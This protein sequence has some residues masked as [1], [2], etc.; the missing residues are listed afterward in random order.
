MLKHN[1]LLFLRNVKKNKTTFLI[2]T[3][4]LGIGIASFLLL[5]L[6]VFNDLTYNHFHD[7]LGNIYRV[8]EGEGVQTK[9]LLL[10]KMLEDIP[11]IEKGTRIFDWDGSRLS[12]GDVAFFENIN[13]VDT[14]FFEIFTFPFVEGPVNKDVQEKYGVVISTEFAKKYFGDTPALGKQLQVKYD[15]MF[16]TVNG[17]VAVPENSSI[18]FDIMASYETGEEVMSWMKEVHNWQNTFSQTYVQ[19]RKG[20]HP[21]DIQD[22]M[23]KIVSENFF[24]VGESKAKLG[25]LP[26]EKYHAVEESN[27]TLIIILAIIALGIIGIA[28]INFINLT[29][30]HS[31]SRIKEM[32]IKKV[33]GATRRTLIWQIMTEAFTTSFIALILGVVSMLVL[34][35]TFNGLF[36][37]NLRF[38][39][40]QNTFFLVILI[41]IWGTIGLLSGFIASMFWA[42]GR[43]IESLKGNL[44]SGKKTSTSRHSLI[45]VQFVIAIV[46][47]SGTILIRKQIDTMLDKDPKFDNENVIITELESWQFENLETASQNFKRIVEELEAS[48]YVESVSFSNNVP[49][50]YQENYNI[51]YP[52]DKKTVDVLHIRKA[53]VGADYFKTLG[54]NLLNGIGFEGDDVS[55]KN[56]VVLNQKAMKDLGFI[57]VSGQMLYEGSETGE[58]YKVIGTID[59]FSYQ[60]VQRE[61]QPLAHFFSERENLADWNYMSVKSKEGSALQVMNL[62]KN[63]WDMAFSGL[64]PNSF[65]ADDKLNEQYKEYVKV[66]TL[67]AWFS[68]LA[69]LLSCMGLFA[70]AS[71]MMARRKKE[72]GIRK[73]NGAT[74]A[75]VLVLLNKDFVKWVALAFV[76][77]VPISS[78]AMGKWLEGFAYKTNISWWIFA[79]AGIV[80]LAIALLT[81]SWQSFRAA[82]NNPV[83][84]LRNE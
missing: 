16:L 12:Q 67:I 66:N 49:G 31:M 72:I 44:F 32:G 33:H 4:G 7:N 69:V 83:D 61:I 59:D 51:F 54:I 78:Y 29:I 20:V 1:I 42:K 63:K 19:L 55:Y 27:Q 10:P 75:Q 56:T 3:I 74:I 18:K 8:R 35:P 64:E 34:L 79:L 9:G 25:L 65:F 38:Q 28:I 40:F 13:Y 41:L 81:V 11:E 23:Q 52:A 84:A 37:T 77:A 39:P 21:A 60:G 43:L 46:L 62:L 22:K 68:V 26:F 76:I 6:Y 73:V 2:N 47:I 53:Y 48:P 80:A 5:A 70:M 57:N 82:T 36:E 24:P 15:N 71:H 14:D 45:V 58:P 30:T 17:V 50:T